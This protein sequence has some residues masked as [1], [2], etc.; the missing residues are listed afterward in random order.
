[1]SKFEALPSMRE[2]DWR[3]LNVTAPHSGNASSPGCSTSSTTLPRRAWPVSS[4]PMAVCPPTSPATA[5]RGA[6]LQSRRPNRRAC[7]GNATSAAPS[8]RPTSWTA[9]SPSPASS[10]I[11]AIKNQPFSAN[12]NRPIIAPQLRCSN[13]FAEVRRSHQRGQGSAKADG[14]FVP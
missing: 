4:S 5:L 9:W 11:R 1:M 6:H 8:S 12:A 2:D 14:L 3:R 10:S 13:K 7:Q